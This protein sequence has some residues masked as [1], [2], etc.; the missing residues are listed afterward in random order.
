MRGLYRTFR[1]KCALAAKYARHARARQLLLEIDA[2]EEEATKTE[3][4]ITA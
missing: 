2:E 4:Q 1:E 3:L